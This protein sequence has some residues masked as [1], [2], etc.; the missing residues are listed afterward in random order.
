MPGLRETVEGHIAI[1]RDQ[2]VALACYAG[3]DPRDRH[4]S[5]NTTGG[6]LGFAAEFSSLVD[7][8]AA[9]APEDRDAYSWA[10]HEW[11]R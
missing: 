1:R 3:A 11:L 2:F 7:T 5:N 4:M 10:D 9:A 6:A 8:T